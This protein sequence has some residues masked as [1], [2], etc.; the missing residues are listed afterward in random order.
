MCEQLTCLGY[1]P[2]DFSS[3]LALTFWIRVTGWTPFL[4]NTLLLLLRNLLSGPSAPHQM[5]HK[6]AI[7]ALNFNQKNKD[8]KNFQIPSGC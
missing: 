7:L 8:E 6:L 2:H 4:H 5:T 3:F 1:P